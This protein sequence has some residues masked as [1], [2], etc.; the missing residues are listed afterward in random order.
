MCIR[1]RY[2]RRV[3]GTKPNAFNNKMAG[4]HHH[5][6][7]SRD[8]QKKVIN[9]VIDCR[10]KYTRVLAWS[11]LFVGIGS[12]FFTR[13]WLPVLLLPIAGGVTDEYFRQ[14]SCDKVEGQYWKLRNSIEASGSQSHH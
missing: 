13:K 6:D 3:R 4:D 1:D 9:D 11:G 10:T 8:K 12:Y 2:Q 7:D 5:H 14:K